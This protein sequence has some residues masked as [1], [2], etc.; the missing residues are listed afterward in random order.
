MK[1]VFL[2]I[3]CLLVNTISFAQGINK[4][5][6][7]GKRHGL[8][9]GTYEASKRPRY[10]GTFE[11]GKETGTFK[12]FEDN[13][14]SALAATRVFA[15]DGSCYTTFFEEKGVKV[16]EGKEVNKEKE[17]EWKFYHPGGTVVM[18][19]ENYSKGKLHGARKTYF[20]DGKIADEAGYI[21][22]ARTGPYKQYTEKGI[23]L[24]ESTYKNGKL[25]G[26]A[27]YRNA[28]GDIVSKGKFAN[29]KKTGIWEF[30]EKGKVVKKEDMTNKKVQL[31][32]KERKN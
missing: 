9:K 16:S 6:A 4:T 27:L 1:K 28:H 5:D 2:I 24:E 17:G 19:L 32:R 3:I 8:W 22:G 29:N 14:K 18:L 12:F 31:A 11:H 21:K 15:A 20:P 23:V 7:E 26:P 30:Y 25:E 13:E 10:E